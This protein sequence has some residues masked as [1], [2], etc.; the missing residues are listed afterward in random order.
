MANFNSDNIVQLHQ[1]SIAEDLLTNQQQI[2]LGFTNQ[3]LD[4]PIIPKPSYLNKPRT[5]RTYSQSN[6]NL[7]IHQNMNHNSSAVHNLSLCS[8]NGQIA[9]QSASSNI[10][11]LLKK[12]F[13]PSIMG[14]T[15]FFPKDFFKNQHAQHQD[16]Q[17]YDMIPQMGQL[18]CNSTNSTHRQTFAL[19]ELQSQFKSLDNRPIQSQQNRRKPQSSSN[20]C[21]PKIIPNPIPHMAA[22]HNKARS[23]MHKRKQSNQSQS[24]QS[25]GRPLILSKHDLCIQHIIQ[26]QSLDQDDLD[27]CLNTSNIL[28][29]PYDLQ[30][31]H[32][33]LNQIKSKPQVVEYNNVSKPHFQ[34]MKQRE[35]LRE[36]IGKFEHQSF[37]QFNLNN[38]RDDSNNLYDLSMTNSYQQTQDV[39][40]N[41]R[42]QNLISRQQNTM[43]ENKQSLGNQNVKPVTIIIS[44]NQNGDDFII[45][46]GKIN[47]AKMG[48]KRIKVKSAAVFRYGSGNRNPSQ[49][50]K[51]NNNDSQI[52]KPNSLIQI[53]AHPLI[54]QQN[55]KH[56]HLSNFIKQIESQVDKEN[57]DSNNVVN[58]DKN[59][60][61]QKVNQCRLR[62]YNAG[63]IQNTIQTEFSEPVPKLQN[64]LLLDLKTPFFKKQES[65]QSQSHNT[66]QVKS[67]TNPHLQITFS[68]QQF[69][70]LKQD[71][72]SKNEQLHQQNIFRRTRNSMQIQ[73]T[74]ISQQQ[75]IQGPSST[76]KQNPFRTFDM[77]SN[78]KHQSNKKKSNKKGSSG[79]KLI[80]QIS[81]ITISQNPVIKIPSCIILKSNLSFENNSGQP[82][83]FRNAESSTNANSSRLQSSKKM[84]S[85]SRKKQSNR[86]PQVNLELC[87][88]LKQCPLPKS[89]IFGNHSSGMK[90]NRTLQRQTS[91]LNPTEL[92][93]FQNSH[94]GKKVQET[95]ALQTSPDTNVKDEYRK[96]FYNSAQNEE[97]QV[98][99]Q[100]V[101]LRITKKNDKNNLSF[102]VEEA[103]KSQSLGVNL[104]NICQDFCVEERNYQSNVTQNTD[105]DSQLQNS[106]NQLL[107][108]ADFKKLSKFQNSSE[109]NKQRMQQPQMNITFTNNFYC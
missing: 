20:I 44:N 61:T 58:L 18:E 5:T 35:V 90:T 55:Q 87:S 21:R 89:Q 99:E 43:K 50:Q 10:S 84:Q 88:S 52:I 104:G 7:I 69:Q 25:M 108:T 77:N 41:M 65:N 37:Q 95:F 40:K 62:R 86:N 26:N 36:K 6:N 102:N 45:K 74:A 59:A 28:E 83:T 39:D 97:D 46:K 56:S 93:Q 73:G 47:T 66:A 103:I 48:E 75:N 76:L 16:S 57:L 60:L 107:V 98:E 68:S 94:S 1:F 3:F 105:N 71:Q 72:Q 11:Q 8:N 2:D 106:I 51:V 85:S 29:F 92:A 54:N 17:Q 82:I 4:H 53:K 109:S 70:Q 12:R 64:N 27:N 9:F 67:T 38:S 14:S 100:H 19:K 101:S 32:K 23:M 49:D 22:F 96:F 34:I 13:S 81:H 15:K 24:S 80:Q 63:T 30:E 42:I 33:N 31:N 78:E 79:K 91:Y